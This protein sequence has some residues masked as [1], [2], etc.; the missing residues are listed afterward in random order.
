MCA[1]DALRVDPV[2][3][4]ADLSAFVGLWF[5]GELYYF[6]LGDDESVAVV[7][8]FG[9]EEGVEAGVAGGDA[10]GLDGRV[11]AL[12]FAGLDYLYCAFVF[13]E[14]EVVFGD[15]GADAL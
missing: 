14:V 4:D 10:F 13:V 1:F 2:F 3:E 15:G 11:E 12:A 9:A 8:D 6:L 5:R 7:E